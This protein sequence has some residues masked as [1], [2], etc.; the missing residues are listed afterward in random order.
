MFA[1]V[2]EYGTCIWYGRLWNLI[3]TINM[4]KKK[5]IQPVPSVNVWEIFNIPTQDLF[6]SSE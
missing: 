1:G 5:N 3:Q 4:K 2:S 6:N